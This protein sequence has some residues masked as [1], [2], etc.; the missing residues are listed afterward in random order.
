MAYQVK[1][2]AALGDSSG[3]ATEVR[4]VVER[5]LDR[6]AG[7]GE[8][9]VRELSETLDSWNPESFRVDEAAV[10]TA[11]AQVPSQLISDIEVALERVDDFAR[12][13]LAT[14]RDLEAETQ[15]GVVL[16]HKHI[17][18]AAV[19][20]YIPGGRYALIASAF[21]SVRTAK[22]AGVDRVVACAPPVGGGIHPATLTAIAMSGADEIYCLG[23]VQAL[24]AMSFGCLPGLDPVDMIIGPGN[25]YVVEAKRQLFGRVGVDLLPGPTEILIVADETAD[26][27]VV[28]ADLI[29]QAEHDP[30][31]RA[32]LITTSE[33]LGRQVLA[34]VDRQLPEVETREVAQASWERNGEIIVV[35]DD[36]EAV[37]EAD[38][39]AAEHLEIQ[40]RDPEWYLARLRNYGTVF[41]GEPA[42]VQY[43][44]KALGPNHILPTRT[45]ARYT[46]GFWVGKLMKTVTYQRLTREGSDTIAPAAN[47]I[48]V[49]EKMMAHART[50]E[51][52]LE[53][54]R[55][56][57]ATPGVADA[58]EGDH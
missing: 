24:G 27:Y 46:G 17:P 34:E 7:E 32:A 10:K 25:K 35:A 55:R 49:A 45:T 28:A 48:A 20:A 31:S 50:G 30:D 42:T 58:A 39:W 18:V 57:K 15:P 37:T 2:A 41:L 19:G 29:G 4:A 40:T 56:A 1:A 36:T 9:A 43:S 54:Y 47:G 21:M 6:I 8:D 51:I 11:R 52:R 22:V 26:P 53:K 33:T 16:G 38:R 13:Q 14:L 5:M 12:R 23:G 3:Q 44:D